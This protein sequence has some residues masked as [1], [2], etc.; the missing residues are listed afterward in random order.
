[1]SHESTRT[2]L[3]VTEKVHAEACAC[4]DDAITPELDVRAV[5]H[6]I[7]HATVFG[8]LSAITVGGSLV[9]V[10]PHNPLPLLRQIEERED[11]AIEVTYL[12][13]GP[14]AWRLRLTRAR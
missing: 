8:A 4:G 7:R 3:P 5:P 6:V 12:D 10:A 13:E 2:E 9:L 11:G 1:M 14:E